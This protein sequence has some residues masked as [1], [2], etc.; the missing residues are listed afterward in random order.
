MADR[1]IGYYSPAFWLPHITLAINDLRREN[2]AC[3]LESVAFE[4]VELTISADNL[5]LVIQKGNPPNNV[6]YQH[7]LAS[8]GRH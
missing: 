6:L 1:A 7:R 8:P 4:P 5:I 3:A 2:L